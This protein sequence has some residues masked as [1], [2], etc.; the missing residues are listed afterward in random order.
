MCISQNLTPSVALTCFFYGWSKATAETLPVVPLEFKVTFAL[1]YY[2]RI[3]ALCGLVK[4]TLK[5]TKTHGDP[6]CLFN[7]IM[8]WK[9]PMQKALLY[10]LFHLIFCRSI[11]IETLYLPCNES[12]AQKA[13][14]KKTCNTNKLVPVIN[15]TGCC[16][17]SPHSRFSISH[18]LQ[19][20][21]NGS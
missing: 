15:I 11:T 12:L 4:E 8:F 5:V 21:G 13:L 17:L 9:A 19:W 18:F 1:Y 2:L 3:M 20:S 16:L 10:F 7:V 6:K 14:H